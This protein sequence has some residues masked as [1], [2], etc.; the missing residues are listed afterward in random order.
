MQKK[1]DIDNKQ[2][3]LQKH[4][5][6]LQRYENEFN[7][8]GPTVENNILN[9]KELDLLYQ[10]KLLNSEK[11]K[12]QYIDENL[13]KDIINLSNKNENMMKINSIYQSMQ[14]GSPKFNSKGENFKSPDIIK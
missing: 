14:M 3:V 10:E 2:N 8:F 5:E 6:T 1:Q 12:F 4:L 13:N 9:E 11:L 7:D